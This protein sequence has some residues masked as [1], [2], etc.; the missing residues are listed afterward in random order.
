M[1]PRLLFL[2]GA[3][4]ASLAAAPALA[5]S[6]FILFFD[7]AG[8]RLDAQ[9]EAIL[10]NA[11][12]AIRFLDVREMTVTGHADRRGAAAAN[13]RLSLRRAEAVKAALVARGVRPETIRVVAAGE[14]EPLIETAD[15]VDEAQNR[16]VAIV[17]DRAC[18]MPP[19]AP[20]SPPC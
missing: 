15:G 6:P 2:A 5:L 17:F 11:A 16:S 7:P 12:A 14:D 1:R 8:A 10:D 19:G 9:D 18:R 4:A 20:V 3:V 13:V